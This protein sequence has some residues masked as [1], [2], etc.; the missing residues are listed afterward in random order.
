MSDIASDIQDFAA[1]LEARH[2]WRPWGVF[3]ETI[4]A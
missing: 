4:A 3:Q 1:A 2:E